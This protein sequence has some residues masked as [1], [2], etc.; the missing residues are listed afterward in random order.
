MQ[1]IVIGWSNEDKSSRETLDW[2]VLDTEVH[3]KE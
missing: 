2:P 3:E 1:E